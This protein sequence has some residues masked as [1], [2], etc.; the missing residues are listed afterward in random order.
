[1]SLSL[2]RDVGRVSAILR[3]KGRENGTQLIFNCAPV[4]IQP[5]YF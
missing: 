5:S 2:H 4:V 1:M 3:Q